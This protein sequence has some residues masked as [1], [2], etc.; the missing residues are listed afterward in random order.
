MPPDDFSVGRDQH[1]RDV[2][3]PFFQ[4]TS[5]P[6]FVNFPVTPSPISPASDSIIHDSKELNHDL[7]AYK[8]QSIFPLH[9][10]KPTSILTPRSSSDS[11][12]LCQRII[13]YHAPSIFYHIFPFGSNNFHAIH[14]ISSKLPNGLKGAVVDWHSGTRSIYVHGLSNCIDSNRH[15]RDIVVKVLDL[16]D[17]DIEADQVIFVLEKHHDRLRE[18][19]QGLLYVGGN[20]IRQVD[21]DETVND[22]LVLVGIEI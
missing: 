14:D 3:A 11:L 6:L 15:L 8:S 16:A 7:L 12:P 4:A 13:S 1:V 9:S 22:D 5:G 20:V 19:L 10:I 17:E 18:L 21:P 2:T